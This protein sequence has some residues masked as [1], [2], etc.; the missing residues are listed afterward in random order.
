MVIKSK[1]FKSTA[2]KSL[3]SENL[4]MI[5]QNINLGQLPQPKG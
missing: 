1:I 2:L 3:K 4:I 5:S